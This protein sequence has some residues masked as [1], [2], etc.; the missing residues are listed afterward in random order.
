MIMPGTEHH[1]VVQVAQVQ[2]DRYGT[3]PGAPRVF[4]PASLWRR[5]AVSASWLF[6]GHAICSRPDDS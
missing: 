2:L 6:Y 3:L 1:L 4:W 5:Q